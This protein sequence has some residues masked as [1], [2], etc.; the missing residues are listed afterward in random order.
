MIF[1]SA[2]VRMDDYNQYQLTELLRQAVDW[3]FVVEASIHHRV[4]GLVYHNLNEIETNQNIPFDIL[5]K[6]KQ[7]YEQT[8]S[9]NLGL[10]KEFCRI[11]EA[12][13]RAKIEPIP[14]KGIIL[15]HTL[16]HNLGLRPII[17][18]D[19]L[20]RE[21]DVSKTEEIIS[22]IGYK[23]WTHTTKDYY[24]SHHCDVTYYLKRDL[25]DLSIV[26]DI[27]WNFV[28]PRPRR[29][30]FTNVWGRAKK[31]LINHTE[32]LLL[33]PEDTLFCLCLHLRRHIRDLLLKHICDISELLILYK[34]RFD[35]DYV[36]SKARGNRMR[37][38]LYFA[39]FSAKELLGTEV[40]E[41]VLNGLSPGFFRRRLIGQ[42]ISKET[43]LYRRLPR[44]D[45]KNY[46]RIGIFLHF[47]I[48]DSICDF[49]IYAILVPIEEF[50]KF[51]SLPFESKKTVFLYHVRFIYIPLRII[52]YLADGLIKILSKSLKT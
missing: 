40:P 42:F 48:L 51:F 34:D 31:K 43:F 25:P 15:T 21:R 5:S 19:I 27:H 30:D 20:V 12:L 7:Y 52:I 17:D 39:L 35:W 46:W 45:S 14:I 18:I 2:R 37:F 50:S 3:N 9:K 36:V 6:L 24:R 41:V 16:Y 28:I 47:L 11:Q 44:L 10:W 26:L 22:Q 23:K 33:S 4:A 8:T 38:T 1:S 13:R 29:I 32:V 49:L